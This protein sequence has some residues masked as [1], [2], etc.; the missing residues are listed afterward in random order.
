MTEK[1][2]SDFLKRIE[3]FDANYGEVKE[4]IARVC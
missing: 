3:W 1:L 2:S 4:N